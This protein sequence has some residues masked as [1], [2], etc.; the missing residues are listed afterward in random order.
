MGPAGTASV[1][2]TSPWLLTEL[3]PQHPRNGY[4]AYELVPPTVTVAAKAEPATSMHTHPITAVFMI[5]PP[6]GFSEFE[7]PYVSC[8]FMIIAAAMIVNNKNILI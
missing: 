2:R 7:Y 1:A 4:A 8:V 3:T 6:C 5:T